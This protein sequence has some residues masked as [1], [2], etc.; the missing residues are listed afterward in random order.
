ME[1]KVKTRRRKD[2]KPSKIYHFKFEIDLRDQFV[3]VAEKA[4]YNTTEALEVLMKKAIEGLL[5]SK[6]ELVVYSDYMKI[7]ETK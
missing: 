2:R 5:P 3:K 4:G 7:E 1:N 6:Q